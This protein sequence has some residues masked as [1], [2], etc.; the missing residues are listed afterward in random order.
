MELSCMS[1]EIEIVL[2]DGSKQEV[3]K[4][5]TLFE[6]KKQFMKQ[7]IVG[8]IDGELVDLAT[9][10]D[11]NVEIVFYDQASK[12]GQTAIN[13]LVSLLLEEAVKELYPEVLFAH[14]QREDKKIW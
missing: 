6:I 11:H 9:P 14:P 12:E 5:T 8:S 10:I 2:P 3:V 13:Q 4:D 1:K 7:A